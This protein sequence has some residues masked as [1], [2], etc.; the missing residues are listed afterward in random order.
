MYLDNNATTDIS[1]S[2]KS[3][4]GTLFITVQELGSWFNQLS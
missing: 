1:L 2:T 3:F 4:T